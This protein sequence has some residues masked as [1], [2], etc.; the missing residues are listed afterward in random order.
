MGSAAL[1]KHKASPQAAQPQ[2]N[3][4]SQ[5]DI[6]QVGPIDSFFPEVSEQDIFNRD[7]IGKD[8]PNPITKARS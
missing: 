7:S 1:K 6:F 3:N 2:E 8:A 5:E 4:A